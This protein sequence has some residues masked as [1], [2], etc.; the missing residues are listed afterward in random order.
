M[1][2]RF[3]IQPQLAFG[4]YTF[5]GK[6]CP[7]KE[8]YAILGKKGVDLLDKKI[9]RLMQY[10]IEMFGHRDYG[11]YGFY[12]AEQVIYDLKT[13]SVFSLIQLNSDEA[14]FN[15]DLETIDAHN[16]NLVNFHSEN[17]WIE[18]NLNNTQEIKRKTRTQIIDII[19]KWGTESIHDFPE[20]IRLDIDTGTL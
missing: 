1:Q 16:E 7:S 4:P 17:Y 20:N 10:R 5:N 2:K 8:V 18:L 19:N 3:R 6:P 9:K 14:A 11:T 13:K 15:W 12:L